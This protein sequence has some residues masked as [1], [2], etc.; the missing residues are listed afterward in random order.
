MKTIK[1]KKLNEKETYVEMLTTILSTPLTVDGRHIPIT[2][3]EVMKMYPIL[4][5]VGKAQLPDI[6]ETSMLLEDAEYE[7][8]MK[9]VNAWSWGASI[10]EVYHF[11]KDMK[12]AEDF[13]YVPEVEKG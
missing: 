7:V 3:E 5:K 4:E 6:G 11:I 2:S 10:K 12:E 8:I 1:L 13:E 9:R